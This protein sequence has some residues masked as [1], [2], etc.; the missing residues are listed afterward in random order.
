MDTAPK[1]ISEFHLFC[2]TEFSDD[3]VDLHELGLIIQ[4]LSRKQVQSLDDLLS[5]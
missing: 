1:L 3:G 2:V 4:A 5:Q